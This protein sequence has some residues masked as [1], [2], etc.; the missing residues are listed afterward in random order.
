[1][2]IVASM[3]LH[4]TIP[5]FISEESVK[6]ALDALRYGSRSRL[7]LS[8]PLE[9][10]LLVDQAL[11]N[12]V[13]PHGTSN[14]RYVLADILISLI[15]DELAKHRRAIG[16]PDEVIVSREHAIATIAREAKNANPE[17]LGWSWMYFHYV[18]VE[19]DI[20]IRLFCRLACIDART[21]QR[22]KEHAVVRLMFRLIDRE[23][24]ARNSHQKRRLYTMLPTMTPLT[25]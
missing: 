21:L 7:P 1:M 13:L 15:T 12:P 11:M 16:T 17:L 2:K 20:S 3:A 8:N 18:R 22:Y 14:R 9:Y 24:V 6:A 5:T 10:L 4:S 19:L 23:R 25:L